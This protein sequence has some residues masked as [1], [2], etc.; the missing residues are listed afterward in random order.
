M[1][2]LTIWM[3]SAVGTLL[4]VPGDFC[5]SAEA[6]VLNFF[7]LSSIVFQLGTGSCQLS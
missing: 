2:S 6:V 3:F 5:L 7:T 1:H 4:G